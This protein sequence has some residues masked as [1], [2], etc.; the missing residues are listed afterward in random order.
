[1]TFT[2]NGVVEQCFIRTCIKVKDP[3]PPEVSS[4]FSF[5]FLGGTFSTFERRV[6]GYRASYAVHIAKPLQAN[7]WW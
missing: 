2:Y 7:L 4:I 5:Y 3:A 6:Y 1:M